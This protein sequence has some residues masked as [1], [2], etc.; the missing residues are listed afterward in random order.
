MHS[1]SRAFLR[2][3]HIDD[4]RRTADDLEADPSLI[5]DARR[6]RAKATRRLPKDEADLA[7]IIIKP[8]KLSLLSTYNQGVLIRII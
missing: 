3:C 8:C 2:L 6:E 5:D 1:V 7:D 4:L